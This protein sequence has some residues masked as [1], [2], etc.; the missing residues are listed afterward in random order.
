MNGLQHANETAA[1]EPRARAVAGHHACAPLSVAA[2][3]TPPSLP[4]QVRVAVHYGPAD[5][6]ASNILAGGLEGDPPYQPVSAGPAAAATNSIQTT[7]VILPLGKTCDYCTLQWVWAARQDGGFYVG[8]ADISITNN[9]AL[10]NFAALP[11]QTGNVLPGVPGQVAPIGGGGG[12]GAI[13][14]GAPPPPGSYIG[15]VQY[16]ATECGLGTGGG[17]LLGMLVG[18]VTTPLCMCLWRRRQAA[19]G[20]G[21]GG[22]GAKDV[23]LRIEGMAAVAVPATQQPPPPAAPPGGLPDGWQEVNDPATGRVYYY[24]APTGQSSWSRPA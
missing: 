18:L 22:V 11:P 14:I 7:S 8:C 15:G 17:F 2:R 19:R 5:S 13:G 16:A 1:S 20:A 21:G 9:G 6:F 23:G 24:H 4:P 12:G 3:A 10:P